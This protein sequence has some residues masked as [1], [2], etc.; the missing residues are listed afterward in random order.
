MIKINLL[1]STSIAQ[2]GAGIAL[3]SSQ[4]SAISPE[5]KKNVAIK[6]V[7]ML[8]LPLSLFVY[9]KLNLGD[10]QTQ[11]SD[12]KTKTQKLQAETAKFGETKPRVEKYHKDKDKIDKAVEIVRG[13]A[14]N[15]LREVKALDAIQS[16]IPLKTWLHKITIDENLMKMEGFTTADDGVP[17]FI[18]VL[19]GSVYFSQVEPRKT[20]Q[21]TIP[22]GTVVKRFELE[23]HLGKHD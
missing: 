12:L 23:M 18:R 3:G 21:E 10:L 17:E 9:E 5:D 22:G 19:E 20:S 15:R 14:R 4:A 8:I 7:L 6:L 1:R 2:T 16:L 13:I 11:V